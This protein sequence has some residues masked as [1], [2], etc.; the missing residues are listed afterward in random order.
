MKLH[1]MLLASGWKRFLND[2]ILD[3]AGSRVQ[4]RIQRHSQWEV[5]SIWYHR[6]LQMDSHCCSKQEEY[7]CFIIKL[8]CGVRK[9]FSGTQPLVLYCGQGLLLLVLLR[10]MDGSRPKQVTIWFS[11]ESNDV[12]GK[13]NNTE[14]LK[15]SLR[16]EGKQKLNIKY[17]RTDARKPKIYYRVLKNGHIEFTTDQQ[18]IKRL[19]VMESRGI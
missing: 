19:S 11:K 5:K 16:E 18:C 17:W 8:C 10:C 7:W 15:V 9:I 6:M 13:H 4:S 14:E 12:V 3:R 1:S 2:W